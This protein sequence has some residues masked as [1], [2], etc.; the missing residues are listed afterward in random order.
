MKIEK[1]T[2]GCE[3]LDE[4]LGGGFEAGTVT[5]IF[6][7]AGSGKTNICLQLAIETVKNGKKVIYIDSEGFSPERFEQ[8][9]GNG[10]GKIAKDIIVYEPMNFEQQYAAIKDLEKVIDKVGVIILDSAATFY[11]FELD[12]ERDIALIRELANQVAHLLGL[13]R[14]HD[15]AVV[16]TNQIYTDIERDQYRPLGG[17]II[18]HLSKV[19][20]QLE[21]VGNGRRKAT[22]RK[23][24]SRPE[25]ISCEFVLT[26]DGVKDA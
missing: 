24:R 19:I 13:A 9:A 2:S 11:R 6:G 1:Y 4:L 5:Q 22:L 10:V 17:N 8:I 7:E 20:V 3:K 15:V 12:D 18:E 14:K 23:H 16:F 26:Q 25:G 21:K